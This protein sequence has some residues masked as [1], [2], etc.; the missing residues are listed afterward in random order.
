M[1]GPLDY[2]G[3]STLFPVT[4]GRRLVVPLQVCVVRGLS[5]VKA[6][7]LSMEIPAP[8]DGTNSTNR[9]FI[10]ENLSE[11]LVKIN[12]YRG[13]WSLRLL[14]LELFNPTDVVFDINVSVQMEDSSLEANSF[15]YP[16]T[17][18]DRDFSARVLIPLEHFKL[19]ILVGT[20]FTKNH[21]VDEKLASETRALFEKNNKAEL[22]ASIKNMVTRIKVRWQSGRN[23][24]GELDIKD[25]VHAAVQASAVDILLPDPLT[26]GFRIA[27]EDK[28]ESDK[29]SKFTT[30]SDGGS[31][32]CILLNKMTPMQFLVR[33]N[34]KDVIRMTLCVTCR[35]V[36][37][38][39]CFEGY[40]DAVLWAGMMCLLSN[41]GC[42]LALFETLFFF[43]FLY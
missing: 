39:N 12:P 41:V 4:I 8:V 13:S 25:A 23:S 16:R 17:R 30:S 33:N 14:E 27:K 40:K 20:F 2:S 32:G 22:K 7:L 37:G 9:D 19:P 1:P 3:E 38:D 15:G 18:I 21:S 29:E 10:S 5:L 11:S 6:R 35:D 24:S 34:T 28:S 31:E 36:R 42:F 43:C 26:I